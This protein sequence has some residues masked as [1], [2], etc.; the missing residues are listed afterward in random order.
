MCACSIAMEDTFGLP[1]GSLPYDPVH[2]KQHYHVV[3]QLAQRH[4]FEMPELSICWEAKRMFANLPFVSLISS[5]CVV[6]KHK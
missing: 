1:T 2:L 6:S 3:A 4:W 5:F